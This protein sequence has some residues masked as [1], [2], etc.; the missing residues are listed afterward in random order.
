MNVFACYWYIICDNSFFQNNFLKSQNENGN[1]LIIYCPKTQTM[2]I[3]VIIF[4]K[5]NVHVII[6]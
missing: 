4:I 2:F 6:L 5:V 3:F 1:K